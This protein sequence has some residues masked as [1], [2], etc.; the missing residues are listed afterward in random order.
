MRDELP[1]GLSLKGGADVVTFSGDKLMGGPQAGILVGKREP[2]DRIRKNPLF[3]A[4]RV[5]K[6]TIAALEATVSLYLQGRL[7]SIPV[8]RMIRLSKEAI[9]CGRTSWQNRFPQQPGF[10]AILRDGRIRNRGRFHP[11]PDTCHILVAMRHSRHSAAK[12]EEV[13]RRQRPAIVGRVEKDE[14]II[15]LRTVA[16]TRTLRSPRRLK[17]CRLR[18]R[19]TMFRFKVKGSI[20]PVVVN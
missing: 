7:D 13:L 19:H 4:L 1:A 3:R 18:L 16:K 17:D 12:L 9:A 6:L 8:L 5:D 14:F 2:L 20:K 15:D 10:T 11:R